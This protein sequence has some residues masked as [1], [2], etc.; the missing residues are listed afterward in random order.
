MNFFLLIGT[1]VLDY[2]KYKLYLLNSNQWSRLIDLLIY[3]KN[4]LHTTAAK[5]RSGVKIHRDPSPNSA[6]DFQFN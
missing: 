1:E 5:N 3:F 6:Y 4:I 2:S